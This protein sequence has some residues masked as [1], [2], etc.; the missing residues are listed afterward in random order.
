MVGLAPA[1]ARGAEALPLWPVSLLL[2]FA[3]ALLLLFAPS[4]P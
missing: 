3:M 1:L 2:G 4:Q